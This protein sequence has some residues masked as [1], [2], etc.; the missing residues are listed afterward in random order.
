MRLTPGIRAMIA[1]AFAFAVMSALVKLAGSRIPSVEIAIVRGVVTLVASY[2]ALRRAGM[3]CCA[4][5]V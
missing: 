3:K 1:A 5:K 2:V 4:R